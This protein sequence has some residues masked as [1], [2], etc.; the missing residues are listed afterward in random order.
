MTPDAMR[1]ALPQTGWSRRWF[2]AYA[3]GIAVAAGTR[4]TCGEAGPARF[5]SDPFSLGVAS[6]DPSPRGMVLWTRLAPRPLEPGGGLGPAPLD[7]AWEVAHDESFTR[8]AAAGVVVADPNLGH[9]VHV[10][11]DGLEPDRWYWYRFRCGDAVS[12]PGRT[13]TLPTAD[14]TPER[15][16]F[17]FA[18]CQNRE[19]GHYAAYRHLAEAGHDLVFHLGD[20][21]YEGPSKGPHVVR[22]HGMPEIHSL[23]DYRIRHALYRSDPLLQ[24]AHAACPWMVTWDDHEVDNNYAAAISEEVDVDPAAFL[25]RRAAAYQ[26]YYEMMPLRRACLPRGPHMRLHRDATFGDLAGFFVL[27]TRQYRGD[28]PNGDGKQELDDAA[29]APGRPMLGDA[30]EAWLLERLTG[31]PARWNILAQ[32]V[33]FG[34]VDR[35]PGDRRLYAMDQWPGYLDARRRLLEAMHERRVANPVVLTGDIHSSWVNDLRADDRRP[36]LPV[37]ATEFVGTGISSTPN[38]ITN[39]AKRDQLL[40]ENPSL[41][42]HGGGNG[43]ASCLA[44]RD[45]LE[46]TYV[47]V[48]DVTR[49][50][51]AVNP[52]TT[53]VVESGRP[54]AVRT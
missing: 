35:T 32:Q 41:V 17:A 44:T 26:A 5:S 54:G 22:P 10:E 43:Y 1:A 45:R 50:D 34:M 36:E 18:S 51:S 19:T 53:F 24:A 14:G 25:V 39:P 20:Y 4:R 49:P 28:Q 13:R 3:A 47:L 38:G 6:G 30:Q 8:P 29:F 16:R 52:S 37:L 48:E 27:D 33:M 2:L 31:S 11:V 42:W 12:P 7:V 9:S 40:A 46:T 23:D 15:V 21:I